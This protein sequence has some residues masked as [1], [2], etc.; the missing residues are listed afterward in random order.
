MER[1]TNTVQL[2][3]VVFMLSLNVEWGEVQLKMMLNS[4]CLL[5]CSVQ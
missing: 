5:Y 3:P 4:N 2:K 1:Q